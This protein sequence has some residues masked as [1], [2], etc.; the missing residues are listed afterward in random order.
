[1]GDFEPFDVLDGTEKSIF[2]V[3]CCDTLG[4]TQY[5]S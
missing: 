3:A 1:M 2:L 4:L 5:Y